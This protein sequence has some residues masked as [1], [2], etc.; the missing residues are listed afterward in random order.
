MEF[1]TWANELNEIITE[2]REKSKKKYDESHDDTLMFSARRYGEHIAYE[3][4]A[5]ILQLF[6][7][8]KKQ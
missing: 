1:D 7:D 8:S 4:A 3:A 6:L 2:L 5:D